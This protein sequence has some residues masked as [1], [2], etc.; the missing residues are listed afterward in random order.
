MFVGI[1]APDFNLGLELRLRK[2]G[3]RTVHY[4]SPSVWAWREKRVYKIA[5]A[6]D[7][8]LCLLPFEPDF[9]AQHGVQADFVG[10]PLANAI[11]PVDDLGAAREAAGVASDRTVLTVLPG[12]RHGEIARLGDTFAAAIRRLSEAR[13][14]SVVLVPL[15]NA[16]GE[17]QFRALPGVQ[18]LPDNVRISQGDAAACMRAADVLLC[19][20]GTVTL[21][22]LLHGK[23]MVM[24]YKLAPSTY[25]IVKSLNLVKLQHFS[26]PNLLT[27]TPWVPEFIQ[28]AA[29][30]AALS[31]AVHGLLS[32]TQRRASIR[33]AF[34][35]V[36]A[37][38]ARNA[39]VR[40][41]DAVAQLALP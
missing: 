13:P 5:K 34:A 41:A 16:T 10:H 15:A 8:V 1:D 4:V 20:S 25:R 35:D 27:A 40:A 32:D 3:I 12:S 21:E 18:A 2:Q 9:Y 38:L 28:D 29:T 7:R 19:A 11:A 17:A 31:E 23:P 33:A 14:D 24:A 37:T 36:H 26:L 22:G 39:D 6:C 30:P